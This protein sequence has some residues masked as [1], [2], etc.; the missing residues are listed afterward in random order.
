MGTSAN[1]PPT[2]AGARTLNGT[3]NQGG[4][5]P[6]FNASLTATTAALVVALKCNATY[7]SWTDA[8]GATE[9]LPMN[10]VT[11]Y[12]A[13]AFCAWDGGFLPTEA[14]WNYAAAGGSDQRAYPWSNPASDLTI[15]C[16]HANYGT[17]TA[18]CVNPPNG[19]VNRVGSESPTG[20]GKWGQADLAGNVYEWTLDAD[21]Y[22]NP[23]T[24]C[25]DLTTE[26]YRV[27]R[28]G[29]FENSASSLRGALRGFDSSGVRY[30]SFGL[31]CGRTP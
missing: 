25:A 21:Q 6:S 1:P 22:S 12:E 18:S 3:A 17:G 26:G 16:S 4:W 27:L 11:W 30:F 20:D 7:Q 15:D 9:G 28:G 2:G 14:E 19:A 24:D 29:S 10:C 23:C 8:P 13:M 5:D 31:R